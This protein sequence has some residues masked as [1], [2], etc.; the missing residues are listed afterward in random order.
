MLQNGKDWKRIW[1]VLN[2]SHCLAAFD[3][4]LYITATLK[5]LTTENEGR[6]W[7]LD[8]IINYKQHRGCPTPT[9]APRGDISRQPYPSFSGFGH[10]AEFFST[11]H[12]RLPFLSILYFALETS[13]PSLDKMIFKVLS[14]NGFS[15]SRNRVIVMRNNRSI[16]HTQ[17]KMFYFSSSH[18]WEK[19]WKKV[20]Q[21]LVI[22]VIK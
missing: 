11:H 20:K 5:A 8:F 21:T 22:H 18:R 9:S 14:A 7:A 6:V 17:K 10:T 3:R 15:W 13:L 12:F 4:S 19:L 16:F 1:G 2:F